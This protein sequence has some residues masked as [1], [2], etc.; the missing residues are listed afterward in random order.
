MKYRTMLL[1]LLSAFV[2]Q[3][4]STPGSV[5]FYE[6]P[7]R[8]DSEIAIISVPAAISM[9]SIDGQ[10]VKSPSKESGTYEV[11]VLP[12][13]HLIVFR[14]YNFWPYGDAGMM[15]KSNDVGVDAVFEAGKH[16]ILRYK[17]PHSFEEAKIFYSDFN[18]NLVDISNGKEYSSFEVSDQNSLFARI[19]NYFD[20]N[21]A[22]KTTNAP[23]ATAVVPIV[24]TA[25]ATTAPPMNADAAMKEDPVKRLKYW[26]LMAN[27]NERKQFTAW[28]KTA[29]ESF[30][31]EPAK[32]P[33]TSKPEEEMKI[34]P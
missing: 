29:T 4:C 13:H 23:A 22:P 5:K 25:S 14:Y 19:K 9:R 3:A 2:L 31:P 7:T 32:T 11:L 18:A 27:E 34:K 30:A 16:Y 28:M 17:E 15:V 21:G 8:P 12:G 6:G 10:N 33:A 26:W 20:P 1:I 24:A